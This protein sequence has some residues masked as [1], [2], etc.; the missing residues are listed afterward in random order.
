M[1]TLVIELLVLAVSMFL[2]GIVIF[3][4]ARSQKLKQIADSKWPQRLTKED[5]RDVG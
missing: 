4:M 2:M 1:Q 5:I 3:I